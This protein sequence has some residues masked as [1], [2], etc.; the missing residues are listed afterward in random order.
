MCCQGRRVELEWGGFSSPDSSRRE[1]A[2]CLPGGRRRIC[3]ILCACVA[4]VVA[5]VLGRRLSG[6]RGGGGDGL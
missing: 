6:L 2:V 5:R 3:L 1:L 4:T